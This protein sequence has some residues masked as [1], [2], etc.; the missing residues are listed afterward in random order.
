MLC[1]GN[2]LIS[3]FSGR[4]DGL[5]IVEL[6]IGFHSIFKGLETFSGK[7]SFHLNQIPLQA[8]LV[9]CLLQFISK[10]ILFKCTVID[11]NFKWIIGLI[12]CKVCKINS[13]CHHP[14]ASCVFCTI[15]TS[16]HTHAHSCWCF[17]IHNVNRGKMCRPDACI[18]ALF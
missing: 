16:L 18:Y 10:Q 6:Y 7:I 12:S 4:F 1:E 15:V 13:G 2:T 14:K 17:S 5:F 9:L 8:Y 3:A 11:L